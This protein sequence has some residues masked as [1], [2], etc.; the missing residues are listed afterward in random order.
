MQGGCD[1]LGLIATHENSQ[2]QAQEAHDEA[3]S[4]PQACNTSIIASDLGPQKA[5]TS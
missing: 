2:P 3:P 5:R 4:P 1:E